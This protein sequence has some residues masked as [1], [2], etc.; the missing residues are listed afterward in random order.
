[1]HGAMQA[2]G[3]GDRS[4]MPG[5]KI[6]LRVIC[7]AGEWAEERFA[8]LNLTLRRATLWCQAIL[9][10]AQ[11]TSCCEFVLSVSHKTFNQSIRQSASP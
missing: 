7:I 5:D 8:G 4:C 6:C 10:H 2:T 11:L 3:W 1:M 9:P